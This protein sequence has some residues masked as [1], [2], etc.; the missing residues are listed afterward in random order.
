MAGLLIQLA[1]I[2]VIQS[3]IIVGL[4]LLRGASFPGGIAGLAVL[5]GCAVLLALPFGAL[6][7]GMAL[8]MRQEES[9]IAAVNFV[10]LPLTFLSSVFMAQGLIPGWMQSVAR[11]NP[12][13]WAVQAGREALGAHADWS[14]VLTRVGWL[15]ALGIVCAWFATGA[16][17][18]YQ[19]SV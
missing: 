17:R 14:Y 13:N 8:L 18:A 15:L 1:V 12:V 6:S 9:V 3:L 19:R 4:G 16:F 2:V 11:F 7:N 10:L 5:V